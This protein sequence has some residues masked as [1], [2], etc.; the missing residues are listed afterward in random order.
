[1]THMFFINPAS[2]WGLVMQERWFLIFRISLML[3]TV[4]VFLRMTLWIYQAYRMLRL[5]AKGNGT[6][7]LVPK[8][9]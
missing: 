1:M 7:Y 2:T 3:P 9:M 4:A 5:Q 8:I 6:F